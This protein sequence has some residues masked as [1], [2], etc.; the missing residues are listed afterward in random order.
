ML[1][2]SADARIKKKEE[3]LLQEQQEVRSRISSV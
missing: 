1:K 3:K 2:A